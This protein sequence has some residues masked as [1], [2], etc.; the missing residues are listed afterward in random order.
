VLL[1]HT[2]TFGVV[3]TTP[4]VAEVQ[5]LALAVMVAGPGTRPLMLKY[6]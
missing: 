6:E 3:V 2:V 4:Y 5:P 1:Q